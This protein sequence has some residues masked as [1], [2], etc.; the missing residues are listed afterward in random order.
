L[1]L[2]GACGIAVGISTNIPPHR[3]AEVVEA[4]IQMIHN[5]DI[6][7]D[8]LLTIM[9]GPDCPTGGT[10]LEQEKLKNIYK[11]GEGTFYIR[12]KV[13]IQEKLDN[14]KIGLIRVYE[15]PFKVNK[16]SIIEEINLLIKNKKIEGIKNVED[17]SN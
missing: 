3:L 16:A 10:L 17:Y 4:T 15:I 1:L 12:A 13:E 9:P 6:S 8:E 5:S 2:N 11:T 7:L 14:K